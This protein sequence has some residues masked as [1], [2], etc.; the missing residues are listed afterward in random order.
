MSLGPLYVFLG[1][2]SVQSLC[3]FFNWAVCLPGVESCEFFIY[4]IYK[5]LLKVN[6]KKTTNPNSTW[7]KDLSRY[8][9]K[10]IQTAN[11][12]LK[13]GPA[14]Y[15]IRELQMETTDT[16]TQLLEWLNPKHWERQIF[17]GMWSSRNSPSLLVRIQNYKAALEISLAVTVKTKQM[18]FYHITQ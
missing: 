4:K 15:V 2:V 7:V 16:T 10:V 14:S 6:K 5:E 8:P 1:K 9:A 17:M 13:R 11:K 18:P 3:P 12:H